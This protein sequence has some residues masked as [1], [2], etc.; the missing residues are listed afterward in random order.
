[1]TTNPSITFAIPYYR[2][3]DYLRHA[4]ASVQ[5]QTRDDWECVVVD[6]AGPESAADRKSTRLNSSH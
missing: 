3:V 1:M 6:D 2:G 4:I 5:A